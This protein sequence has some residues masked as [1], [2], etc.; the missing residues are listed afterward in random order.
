MTAQELEART[1]RATAPALQPPSPTA[2]LHIWLSTLPCTGLCV[3]PPTKAGH[4]QPTVEQLED[5]ESRL[6]WFFLS[7]CFRIMTLHLIFGMTTSGIEMGQ[8]MRPNPLGIR[9]LGHYFLHFIIHNLSNHADPL[10]LLS[11]HYPQRYVLKLLKHLS[12][13]RGTKPELK[14]PPALNHLRRWKLAQKFH[15]VQV[16]TRNTFQ[17]VDYWER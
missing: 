4:H 13:T 17:Q 10:P 15:S 1:W 6:H 8:A 14:V 2:S 5:S 16:L 9:T 7:C 12:P 3:K 11:P